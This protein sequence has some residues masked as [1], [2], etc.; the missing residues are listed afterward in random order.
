MVVSAN[1]ADGCNCCLLF[2]V[3]RLRFGEKAE[4]GGLGLAQKLNEPETARVVE[5]QEAGTQPG[6]GEVIH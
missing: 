3:C 2:S 4:I 5:P 1:N 6:V